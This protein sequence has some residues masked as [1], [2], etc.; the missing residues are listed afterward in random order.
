MEDMFSNLA[1]YGYIVVFLYSLGGGFVALMAAGVLSYAGKMDLATSMAIAFVANAIGDSLLFY[2]GRYHKRDI[3]GYMHKHKRK[4]ALSHLLMKK[5]GSWVI[6][7]Q[8]FVYGIKTLIPIA[9]GLTRYDFT[10]FNILN[11]IA[12]VIWTV[13]VGYG[14]YLAGD[15]LT[16]AYHVISERPYIAPAV[17]F[18]AVGLLWLYMSKATKK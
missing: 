5:Y 13:V 9:I 8:K 15:A 4:L 17:L 7:F 2:M 18:S 12:A 11:A 3:M 6:I 16:T 10:K 1:T 14:S